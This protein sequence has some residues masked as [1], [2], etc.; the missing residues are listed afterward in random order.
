MRTVISLALV[1][2]LPLPTVATAQRRDATEPVTKGSASIGGVLI[3]D[4][5]KRVSGAIVTLAGDGLSPSRGAV[6]DGEGRFA[7]TDLPAGRFMLSAEKPGFVTSGFGAKRPGRPGTPLVVA[8]A[9][10][11]TDLVVRIWRGAAISGTLID[12]DGQPLP[13]ATIRAVRVNATGVDG[14]QTLTSNGVL[15][16]ERGEFRIYGLQPGAYVVVASP[17]VQMASPALA[18]GT[19]V[20]DAIL[21]ELSKGIDGSLPARLDRIRATHPDSGLVDFAPVMYPGT[22]DV[23]GA[24]PIEL[25][26]GEERSGVNMVF[27]RVQVA[28]LTGTV[29]LPTGEPA[30]GVTVQMTRRIRSELAVSGIPRRQSVTTDRQGRFMLLKV[31]P[32]DY[33]VTARLRVTEGRPAGG[34]AGAQEKGDTFWATSAV[35]AAPR[36]RQELLLGLEPGL[37]VRG[38]LSATPGG[39]LNARA[40]ERMS[41]ALLDVSTTGPGAAEDLSL[42]PEGSKVAAD[43]SFTLTG[44]RPGGRYRF[45]ASGAEAASIQSAVM[46]AHDFYDAPGEVIATAPNGDLAVTVS[47][48]K[49]A[50]YGALLLPDG[51]AHSDVFVVVFPTDP[52]LWSAATRRARATR[53]DVN[54]GY[55]F[56]D[57]PAGEYFIGA[58]TDVD[59]NEWTALDHLAVLAEASVRVRLGVGERARQDLRLGGRPRRPN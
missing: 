31:I 36:S 21:S 2:F 56:D 52:T 44:L 14:D 45:F 40:L 57:L 6:T 37:T 29:R 12:E 28:A 34:T 53:P 26:S 55:V 1:L 35:S 24:V 32:G 3:S 38:R 17:A 50:I 48:N 20:N 19:D 10:A 5:N 4:E 11:R 18:R 13:K 58:L 9:H 42:R 51:A 23:D 54:G 41:V 15:T 30:G 22:H 47:P 46:G 27:R 8:A 25:S 33:D 59:A 39:A 43:G 7:L 16:N 49:S